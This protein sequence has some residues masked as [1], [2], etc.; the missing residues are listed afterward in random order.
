MSINDPL[1]TDIFT[2]ISE[3]LE[4]DVSVREILGEGP[5]FKLFRTNPPKQP[6]YPLLIM[7][8]LTKNH[9]MQDY[10]YIDYYIRFLIK[11]TSSDHT[12]RDKLYQKLTSIFSDPDTNYNKNNTKIESISIMPTPGEF[13]EPDNRVYVLPETIMIKARRNINLN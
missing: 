11:S 10:L 12:D 3:K 13:F 6:K 5:S 9:E 4:A 2:M 1:L 8:F 7:S